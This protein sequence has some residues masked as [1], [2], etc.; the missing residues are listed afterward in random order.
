[1]GRRSI[2]NCRPASSRTSTRFSKRSR[3]SCEDECRGWGTRGLRGRLRRETSNAQPPTSNLQ[4][5]KKCAAP[6]SRLVRGNWMLD[7][8]CSMLD[9]RSSTLP[10][11]DGCLVALAVFKTV[12]GSFNGSRYVRFVPSPP[13]RFATYDLRLKIGGNRESRIEN[14]GPGELR[15]EIQHTPRREVVAMSRAQVLKLT[16]LSSCAG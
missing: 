9:V 11:S 4:P 14:R 5:P 13:S 16:A 7:L 2:R 1:M 3:R 15:I 6:P 8:G 12:V 10:E